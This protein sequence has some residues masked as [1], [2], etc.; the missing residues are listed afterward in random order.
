MAKREMKVETVLSVAG[1]NWGAMA[2]VT[3]GEDHETDG[4]RDLGLAA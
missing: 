4:R 2:K 3:R 1:K